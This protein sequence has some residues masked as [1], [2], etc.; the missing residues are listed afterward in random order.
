[1]NR[2]LDKL[3]GL[4]KTVDDAR[5]CQ[6]RVVQDIN[7]THLKRALEQAGQIHQEIGAELAD[8]L[9]RAGRRPSRRGSVV[10]ALRAV[11]S[12]WLAS[13]SADDEAAFVTQ[14][15]GCETR[16]LRRFRSVLANLD[17][18]ELQYRLRDHQRQIE[19]V[20]LK[21]TQFGFLMQMQATPA[22]KRAFARGRAAVH[23]PQP[24]PTRAG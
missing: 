9:V 8:H 15:S 12:K 3:Q 16:V 21:I 24:Q 20:Y 10:G 5:M 11:Y 19:H 2:E 14:A 18:S 13:I 6:L 7:H 4:L 1:M 17:D 22:A 23:A